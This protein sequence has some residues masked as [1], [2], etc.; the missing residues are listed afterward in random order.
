MKSVI[1]PP[2]ASEPKIYRNR[3]AERRGL[4]GQSEL[5]LPPE[6]SSDYMRMREA[7]EEYETAIECQGHVIHLF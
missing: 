6:P 7:Y 4:Y 5:P 3:A 2:E 1:N